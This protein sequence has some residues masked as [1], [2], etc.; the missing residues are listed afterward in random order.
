[1]TYGVS[2]YTL[3]KLDPICTLPIT[4]RDRI[5]KDLVRK[6]PFGPVGELSIYRDDSKYRSDHLRGYKPSSLFRLGI[7]DKD[8]LRQI[9]ASIV[10]PGLTEKDLKV[11]R[12][13][14]PITRYVNRAWPILR[15]AIL[16]IKSGGGPGVYEVYD[17][18]FGFH[19][20]GT[21]GYVSADDP[22]TALIIAKTVFG[23]IVP[24]DTVRVRFI[25]WE[26]R[27]C[28]DI[29]N[30]SVIAALSENIQKLENKKK[31][32]DNTVEKNKSH[33]DTLSNI[34][35]QDNN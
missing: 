19:T 7:R 33:M 23:F 22:T 18:R 10:Y 17:Y 4:H 5:V 8:F 28:V 12:K 25:E 30:L 14:G 3:P 13:S 15:S 2:R 20:Y 6:N 11:N 26:S 35:R 34:M 1:M 21:M 16:S 31:E 32:I 9:I 24:D 27:D 29:L